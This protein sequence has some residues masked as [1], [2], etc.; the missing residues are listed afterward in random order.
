M[1]HLP[2]CVDHLHVLRAHRHFGSLSDYR[3]SIGDNIR[4]SH[5]FY[6]SSH[7]DPFT[8]CSVVDRQSLDSSVK[9]DLTTGF[10]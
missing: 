6:L 7:F 9:L 4:H 8:S 10:I 5:K 1:L 3:F 2:G